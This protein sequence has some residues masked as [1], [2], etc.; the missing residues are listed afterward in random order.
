MTCFKRILENYQALLEEWNICLEDTKLQPDVRGRVIGCQT[1]MNTFSF[2]FGLNLGER[3]F[4]HTDNLSKTLQ[5]EKMSAVSGQRMAKL[6]TEVLRSFRN[7]E[8]FE[9]FY[10]AV[11]VKSKLH[12]SISEP[13][14]PRRTRAPQRYE[15]GEGQG[16]FPA[17]VTEYYKRTYFEAL[18]LLISAIEEVSIRQA[19][20]PIKTWNPCY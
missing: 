11:V 14:L 7:D 9:S 20:W 16:S 6:T 19:L 2:F 1:Q 8:S 17:T 12:T 15:I 18:D 13:I 10:A 4:A 5:K 3:L